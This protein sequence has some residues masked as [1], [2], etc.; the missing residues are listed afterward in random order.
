M[1]GLVLTVL[2]SAVFSVRGNSQ[3]EHE[4]GLPPLSRPVQPQ[5]AGVPWPM[6]QVMAST[7]VIYPLADPSIFRIYQKS[8]T[9]CQ[10]LDQAFSRYFNIIFFG[11]PKLSDEVR[12]RKLSEMKQEGRFSSPHGKNQ[13]ALTTLAVSITDCNE[14]YP[15]LSSSEN[16]TLDVSAPVAVLS[17]HSQWGALRG[18]ETFSQLVYESSS[19]AMLIVNKTSITDYPRFAH[20]GF[21][22][23]SSRHFLPLDVLLQFLDAMSY[24]KFNVFHWHIVDDQSFPYES[25]TYPYMSQQGAYSPSYVYNQIDVKRVIDYARD[26]G[27]RVIPEFDTPGHTQSWGSVKGLLTP[28][29]DKSGK[30]TGQYGPIN[31]ILNS[32][33]QFLEPFFREVFQVFPDNYIHVGGD[34]VSFD[35]W[36]SNKDIQHF[37]AQMGFGQNYSKLE[38]YYEKKFLGIVENLLAR[39]IVWQEV[40]DNGVHVVSNAVVHVWKGPWQEELAKVTRLGYKTLLSTPWYLNYAGNPYGQ[41]WK[42][43]YA[44]EPLMFNGTAAQKALVFGGEACMWGEYV[45]ATNLIQ[46]SWPRGCAV[47]ERLWSAENVRDVNKAAP[48]LA[49][50]RCRMVKRGLKAEPVT[51]PGF[52]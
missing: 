5:S 21:L 33:Y 43:A 8:Q 49:E 20:R 26:R 29:E 28:C 9:T 36:K 25:T 45:D 15:S 40:V 35:C 14:M 46:R 18:L 48:R 41:D 24:N 30:P 17:A 23:D 52:C 37:M 12:L 47:A 22:V 32:T 13:V 34:E 10:L 1:L 50:Q 4:F 7:E 31:P 44:V 51:G 27:I 42:T 39:P 16:Y 6:P 2:L 11:M 3:I 38:A 19:L